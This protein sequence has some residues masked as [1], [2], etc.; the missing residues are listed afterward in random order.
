MNTKASQAVA[1]ALLVALLAGC[2]GASHAVLPQTKA[3][4]PTVVH[5]H[6]GMHVNVRAHNGTNKR[7]S[8]IAGDVVAD[9]GFESGAFG[10]WSA[11]GNAAATFDSSAPHSGA[12]DALV[13]NLASSPGEETGMDGVC[14]TVTV[15]ASGQLSVWVNEGTSETSTSVADQEADLLDST[16][17]V[18]A[19]LYSENGNTNGYVQKTFDLSSYAGQT[20]QLFFGIYG[21]GSTSDYNYVYVDDVSLVGASGSTPTP[22]PTSTPAAQ[23]AC[24]DQQ[25]VN[26]VQ[27]YASGSLSGYT[28]EDVCGVVGQVLP[29]KTTRSGLHGYFYMQI[30][31]TNVEIVSNLDV[32]NAPAWPW[33]QTGDYVYVQ[34]R[35]Y[36]DNASSIGI[37]WTHSGATSG[38]PSGGYVVVCDANAN[39]CN[40][41]Q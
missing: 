3:L 35:M 16:G 34:G 14:Q 2:G 27:S 10:A 20:V 21:S 28:P 24:S 12:Y 38:L 25:F 9:G 17:N 11:C 6:A 36:Y 31:S 13:G 33:V 41:Y 18:I 29:S 37:D 5:N 39:N 1:S 7:H 15:P 19:T 4:A 30:G 40:Q 22:A 32:M 23:W 8:M 26:D